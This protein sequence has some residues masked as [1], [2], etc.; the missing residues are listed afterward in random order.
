MYS[1]NE[2]RVFL[3]RSIMLPCSEDG[4]HI[5]SVIGA[6]TFKEKLRATKA[7]QTRPEA[8][9]REAPDPLPQPYPA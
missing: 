1:D 5:D 6:I 2:G 9:D 4:Q 7:L 3:F 8:D